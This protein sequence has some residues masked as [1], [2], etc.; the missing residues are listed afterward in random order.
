[1]KQR[2]DNSAGFTLIEVLIAAVVILFGLLAMA[3]FLGNLVSKN[4]SNERKT[5]AT[6][7]AQEKIEDLRVD[8][9]RIDITGTGNDTI[10][11]AAGTFTRTWSITDAVNPGDPDQVSVVVDWD[12]VG[13]SQVTIVTLISDN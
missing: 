1:M 4:A 12:G 10:T 8:A 6:T 3:S 5:M 2:I 11:T 7:L 9:Q 13:N